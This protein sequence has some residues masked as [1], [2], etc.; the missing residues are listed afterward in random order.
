MRTLR[1][2]HPENAKALWPKKI[3]FGL[4]L[5]IPLSIAYLSSLITI[6]SV[7]QLSALVGNVSVAVLLFLSLKAILVMIAWGHGFLYRAMLI[8]L[9]RDGNNQ[10]D[11]FESE[12][13]LLG[14]LF[15]LVLVLSPGWTPLTA[16]VLDT[17]LGVSLAQFI[18]K[19]LPGILVTLWLIESSS[20]VTSWEEA[21]SES[22]SRSSESLSNPKQPEENKVNS[23]NVPSNTTTVPQQASSEFKFR[24]MSAPSLGL[25]DFAGYD[26][27]KY[28]VSNNLAHVSSHCRPSR[29]DPSSIAVPDPAVS[30][31]LYGSSGTGKT[32]LAR[33]IAGELGGTYVEISAGDVLSPVINQSVHQV[34]LLFREAKQI[35]GPTVIFVDELESV[36]A[37]RS[38]KM[39]HENRQVVSEFLKQIGDLDG[40]NQIYF[41]GVTSR[42]SILDNAAFSP[43]RFD[44]QLEVGLPDEESRKALV[45][46]YLQ[47]HSHSMDED[48][49]DWLADI[50]AGHNCAAIEEYIKSA[51][52]E[53]YNRNSDCLE[54]GDFTKAGPL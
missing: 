48:D 42:P 1:I 43:T 38:E 22:S 18:F 6:D 13:Y 25:P 39:P 20:S 11:T 36:L 12:T 34:R 9:I 41:I 4:A 28:T 35:R 26:D 44:L 16:H 51:S 7:T 46:Y 37:K 50:S 21:P 23:A 14:I 52:Q 29:S 33:S 2:T 40:T 54:P 24:W 17:T 3:G 19:Y 53:A 10:I 47:D 15:F 8:F 27:L 5:V 30:F 32:R 49:I 45:S 31:L